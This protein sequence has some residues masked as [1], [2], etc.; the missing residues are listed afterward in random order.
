MTTRLTTITK[1]AVT[2]MIN[3]FAVKLL[4]KT[5]SL[6][7]IFCKM[8][9]IL[10][11]LIGKYCCTLLGNVLTVKSLSK[12]FGITNITN[13]MIIDIKGEFVKLEIKIPRL[14]IKY[15]C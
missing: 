6:L 4:R 8:V 12:P 2:P 15:Q 1:H 10:K 5:S 3:R 11:L 13:D 7:V 9:S 14:L